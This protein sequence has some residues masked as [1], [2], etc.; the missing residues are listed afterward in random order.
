MK[1]KIL[2]SIISIWIILAVFGVAYNCVKSVAEIK[3][4]AFLSDAQKKEMLFGDLYDF[5]VFIEKHTNK[6]AHILIFSK[7]V[8]T[9]YYSIYNLYPRIISVATNKQDLAKSLAKT[10]YDY[11]VLYDQ[12]A[13]VSGYKLE[14]SY[15]SKL[16]KDFGGIYKNND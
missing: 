10:K 13:S 12:N 9:F 1:N 2:L 7:D 16:T 5:L 8:R 3:T 14:A 4:W 6:N 15:S 11:V